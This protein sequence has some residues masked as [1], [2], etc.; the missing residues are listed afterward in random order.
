MKMPSG[1]SNSIQRKLANS[2]TKK[3]RHRQIVRSIY[4]RLLKACGPRNWW[5]AD[6]RDEVIIGTVLTQNTAW[7]NVELALGNLKG[8]NL[9]RLGRIATTPPEQIAELIRPSGYFN[10]KARRLLSVAQFFA[11][12]GKDRS[13]D[14][15]ALPTDELR[16]QL[17]AVWGIGPE[18]VDSI[19]LY[20]LGRVS[21]VID[22]YTM[23]V[24]ERHGLTPPGAKYEEV[25]EFFTGHLES[26]LQLFNEYHALLVW[27]GHHYCKPKPLCSKCPLAERDLH[28]TQAAWNRLKKQRQPADKA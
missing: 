21:F 25:R 14:L 12:E 20:A 6:H 28:A 22:A 10:L 4:D 27:A 7:R 24:T 17:L 15:D 18:S 1:Y 5:P 26:D 9:L 16:E 13:D 3:E 23:R 19:L 2:P 11:P 8:E